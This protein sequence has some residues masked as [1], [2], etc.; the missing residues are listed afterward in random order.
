VPGD[1]SEDDRAEE[2]EPQVRPR[3]HVEDADLRRDERDQDC[4]RADDLN[5]L[6]H[7]LLPPGMALTE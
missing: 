5:D 6:A 3:A 2:V 7:L 4:K 1:D